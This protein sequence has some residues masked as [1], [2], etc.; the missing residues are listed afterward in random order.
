[1]GEILEKERG[2]LAKKFTEESESHQDEALSAKV[3][4]R[5]SGWGVQP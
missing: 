2:Q 5:V 3:R 1:M 4:K